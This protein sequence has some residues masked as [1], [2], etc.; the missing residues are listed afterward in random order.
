MPSVSLVK[1]KF[2][3]KYAISAE[4][5]SEEMV[6]KTIILRYINRLLFELRLC[7]ISCCY[8]FS[9]YLW[10]WASFTIHCQV[11]AKS[12]NV[13]Y[14]KG[15]VP[16]W[17]GVP[18][19]VAIPFGTFEKVLSDEINKV[20]N[21]FVNIKYWQ[22]LVIV[23]WACLFFKINIYLQ[24]KKQMYSLI[25]STEVLFMFLSN[26]IFCIPKVSFVCKTQ[27]SF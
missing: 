17:V 24:N 6:N 25:F 14:L 9:H 21:F 13:A 23:W 2:L 4:E 15:K 20:G 5:F 16:S 19:S 7:R 12:R 26:D 1:K 27:I 18:T 10:P 11:G 8:S 22:E 3:G